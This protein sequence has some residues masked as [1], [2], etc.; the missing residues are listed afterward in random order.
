MNKYNNTKAK[1]YKQILEKISHTTPA[2]ACLSKHTPCWV[3]MTLHRHTHTHTGPHTEDD[4]LLSPCT[5]NSFYA[6][7][8]LQVTCSTH[9]AAS[10]PL[11][12]SAVLIYSVPSCQITDGW[13]AQIGHE[14]RPD[15]L[16]TFTIHRNKIQSFRI[17][18][19]MSKSQKVHFILFPY[20]EN[21]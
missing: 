14:P 19:V 20:L 12:S 2:I 6:T 1:S 8:L 3:C 7:F 5:E 16:Q 9:I 13:R 18:L 11:P 21:I 17:I 15:Y 10:P 4:Q